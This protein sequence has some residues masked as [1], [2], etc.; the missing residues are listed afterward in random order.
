MRGGEA[1]QRRGAGGGAST[2]LKKD[3]QGIRSSTQASG[4]L[5]GT[6]A[7]SGAEAG[8]VAD[9]K[10]VKNVD[11]TKGTGWKTPMVPRVSMTSMVSR[12]PVMLEG[13]PDEMDGRDREKRSRFNN[14]FWLSAAFLKA[15]FSSFVFRFTF[16]AQFYR[17]L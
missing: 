4:E 17:L 11:D 3:F 10:G 2:P 6:T 14:G 8:S 5:A 15:T 7:P 12:V 1:K 16:L 13:M 9:I